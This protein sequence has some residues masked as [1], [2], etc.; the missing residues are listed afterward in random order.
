MLD[1]VNAVL[2]TGGLNPLSHVGQLWSA[3]RTILATYA[4]LDHHRGADRECP[5]EGRLEDDGVDTPGWRDFGMPGEA[6]WNCFAMAAL[7]AAIGDSI[8]TVAKLRGNVVFVDA[9]YHIV[10]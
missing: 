6:R 5:Y 8:Q 1:N 7:E 3:D 10:G 9:G 4:E 2:A